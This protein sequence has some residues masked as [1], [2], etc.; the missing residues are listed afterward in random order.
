LGAVRAAATIS[1]ATCRAADFSSSIEVF[2]A[3]N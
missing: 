3:I 2:N 1:A